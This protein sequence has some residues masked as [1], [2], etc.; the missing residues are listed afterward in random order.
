MGMKK[1]ISNQIFTGWPIE[2]AAEYVAALGYDGLEFD[3]YTL[4][5]AVDEITPEQRCR[6]RQA[7]RAQDLDVVGFHSTLKSPT[8]ALH[9]NHPDSAIRDRTV[10]YLAALSA[11]CEDLGAR[12]LVLGSPKQ[13]GI[14]PDLTPEEAWG[15]A[16]DTIIRALPAAERH[17]VMLCLE[18]IT[19]RLTDFMTTAAEAR[20][21]VE[22]MDHPHLRMMIDVRSASDDVAPIPD[23]IRQS[24]A[25]L[26]HIHA[27]DDNGRGPG[28]GNA[29]YAGIAGALK[30]ISYQGYL[31]VEVFDFEQGPESIA[32]ESMRAL[33]RYFG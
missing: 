9:I 10:A 33:R 25:Y 2:R 28:Q 27:N 3:P 1:A 7:A 19:H 26:E 17:G 32:Q 15:L 14:H 31:S 22:E 5:D 21:M 20:R 29:D 11:L 13:R 30:E 4:A 23:L 16:R 12:I 8:V 18:P 6:I 24:A